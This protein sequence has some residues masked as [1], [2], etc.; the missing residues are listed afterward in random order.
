MTKA[1]ARRPLN[2][3]AKA[4]AGALATIFAD[5]AERDAEIAN[6]TVRCLTEFTSSEEA[7]ELLMMAKLDPAGVKEKFGF[8]IAQLRIAVHALKCEKEVPYALKMAQ[9][10]MELRQKDDGAAAPEAAR[11]VAI[12]AAVKK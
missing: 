12:P 6:E 10:R 2:P 1:L 4:R 3:V 5:V 11:V 9:R 8:T 7:E